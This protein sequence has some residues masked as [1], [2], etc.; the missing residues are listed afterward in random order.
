MSSGQRAKFRYT[1]EQD[2]KKMKKD[3]LSKLK[4][5]GVA[6]VVIIIVVVCWPISCIGASGRGVRYTFGAAGDEVL[7]PGIN[8]HI[9]LISQ[10]RTWDIKPN[11]YDLIININE[12]GAVS[13][14]NQIIGV[15]G[16]IV[17]NLDPSK[18]IVFVKQYGGDIANLEN[19]IRN[20]SY[21]SLKATIGQYTIYD[22][23]K[24][25]TK[26][27]EQSLAALMG[28]LENYPILVTQF[29]VTNFDWSPEFDQRINET[30][31]ATQKVKEME[32]QAAIAEQKAKQQVIESEAQ[33]KALVAKAEGEFNAA[34][35][36]AEAEIE[37]ARGQNEANRLLSQ[38]F[39]VE[40]RLKELEIE[41]EKAKR[42]DGRQV[43]TY[44][45][46]N[47]AGGVVTLP[48]KP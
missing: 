46:L 30:M 21:E 4:S 37:A 35:L 28:K 24:S 7:Q 14:D 29:N 43:P 32:Q 38:N 13:S 20:S 45:P 25:M 31:A 48:A 44:I 26:I 10:I 12:R 8:F 9:P 6:L 42:W 27:A 5:A 3:I 41:L 15:E 17:W 36:R 23:P 34:K 18:I 2:G 39:T 22:L 47:P 1:D 33:A 11:T 16:K 19:I 40:V